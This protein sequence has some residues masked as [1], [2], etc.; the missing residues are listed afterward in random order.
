MKIKWTFV[1]YGIA[2]GVLTSLMGISAMQ[3]KF[4]VIEI[5][6]IIAYLGGRY[7]S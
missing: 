4:W 2:V 6:I 7:D 5:L 1:L 3:W